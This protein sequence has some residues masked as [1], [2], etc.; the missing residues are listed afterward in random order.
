MK[1]QKHFPKKEAF[2]LYLDRYADPKEVNKR[3]LEKRL[4]NTHPFDG[5]EP[6][7]QFPNAHVFE[8]NTPTW[9]KTEIRKERLKHGRI[10]DT[11]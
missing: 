5:P 9:L 6:P 10:N 2:N 7:L 8:E 3:F 11:E 1:Y 4:A